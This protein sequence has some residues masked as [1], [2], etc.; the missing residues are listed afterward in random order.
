[1]F[2]IILFWVSF[3]ADGVVSYGGSSSSSGGIYPSHG[4]TANP[5]GYEYSRAQ[6]RASLRGG[7]GSE[8]TSTSTHPPGLGVGG[9]VQGP[10]DIR[11]GEAVDSSEF[12][13]QPVS[14]V[15]PE[16]ATGLSGLGC[17]GSEV[18]ST[19]TPEYFSSWSWYERDP[20]VST[21]QWNWKDN[22]YDS[23]YETRREKGQWEGRRAGG[24]KRGGG[25]PW[26]TANQGQKRQRHSVSEQVWRRRGAH[27]WP[28][29]Q[30]SETVNSTVESTHT[31]RGKK[32]KVANVEEGSRPEGAPV[33]Q[34]KTNRVKR[35]KERIVAHRADKKKLRKKKRVSKGFARLSILHTVIKKKEKI[36]NVWGEG[37][38]R[39][40]T[41]NTRLMGSPNGRL[42]PFLKME[43][44]LALFESRG[45]SFALLSDMKF[46][47]NGVRQYETEKQTMSWT[48]IVQGKVA[49]MLNQG[50]AELWRKSGAILECVGRTDISTT[51]AMAI[52][53]KQKGWQRGLRLISVYAPTSAH[54]TMKEREKYNKH[55]H[56]LLEKSAAEDILV[57]GGDMNAQVGA[58][59]D[60]TNRDVLGAFGHNNRTKTGEDLIQ[61]CREE[62]LMVAGSF[63]LQNERSTWWHPAHGTG[64]EID[65]LLVRRTQRWHV[66]A[67]K[68]L[69][70]G[71]PADEESKER[72]KKEQARSRRTNTTWRVEKHVRHDGVI[73]WES[74]TDH[75]PVEIVIRAGKNW[76]AAAKAKE[77]KWAE[78][79]DWSKVWGGTKEA[80]EHKQRL[81]EKMNDD[82]SKMGEN[83]EWDSICEVSY[84]AALEILGAK[85]KP[86]PRPWLVGKETDKAELDARVS[87]VKKAFKFSQPRGQQKHNHP[88]QTKQSRPRNKS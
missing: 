41:W 29:G 35:R 88:S 18:T 31:N 87:E 69:H 83:S 12:A 38:L 25:I 2:T 62:G 68:T 21:P 16:I 34:R 61:L 17:G 64:H 56:M 19:S 85:G 50:L 80:L 82:I 66:L 81:E 54:S 1:L 78:E 32:R 46:P 65:H 49:I 5:Y 57:V 77:R 26:E 28:R 30:Q 72:A 74:Y 6:D 9:S 24:A 48:L 71:M 52:T 63:G 3:I 11:V 58:G 73:A 76:Q 37:H 23:W 15:T 10:A 27:Q 13:S 67:C 20:K 51:R 39:G 70:Y 45:W 42:D 22:Q 47:Q 4:T 14:G 86:H 44:F 7:W 79:P 8:E 75:H 53:I 40:G 59:K 60:T 55:V 84:K 36:K 43:C 33:R